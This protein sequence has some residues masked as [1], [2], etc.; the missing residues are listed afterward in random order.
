MFA[1][2]QAGSPRFVVNV[3]AEVAGPGL[4]VMRNLAPNGRTVQM[5]PFC[6][7]LITLMQGETGS[8]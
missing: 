8:L 7:T 4:S 3:A 2:A 1:I 5:V 6:V